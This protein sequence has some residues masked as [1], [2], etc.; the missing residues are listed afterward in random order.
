MPDSNGS[1]IPGSDETDLS[2]AEWLAEVGDRIACGESVDL[3][4]LTADDPGKAERLRRLVPALEMM[5]RL[6]NRPGPPTEPSDGGGRAGGGLLGP[7]G[8]FVTVRELG[9]GGMGVVYEAMQ[10]SLNRPVALKILPAVSADDPSRLRRFRVE[11][12]AAACLSHPHIVPVYLVGS[13]GGT[14]FYAMKLVEGKTLARVIAEARRAT[15]RTGRRAGPTPREAAALAKQAAEALQY[16]HEQGIVHRDVKPSNLLVEAP[17]WL[18]VTDF[19]LARVP[20]AADLSSP[21]ALLCTLRYASP[22]QVVGDRAGVNHRTDV[23][24]LGAT[25]YELVSLRPAFPIDDRIA[26]LKAIAGR[27]PVPLR[28]LDPSV[29][30][31][32]ETVVAKAMAKD[33]ARRYATA[34]ELAD[35]LGRFLDD[36]PIKARPAGRSDRLGKFARRHRGAAAAAVA[37]VAVGAAAAVGASLWRQGILAG[38]NRELAVALRRAERNEW[39]NRKLWYGSQIRLARQ[40]F[41]AGQVEFAQEV[42]DGLR[43]GPRDRDPRGF[44]WFHLRRL[45]GRDLSL[46]FGHEEGVT[47]LAVSA[48]GKTLATGDRGGTVVFWDLDRWRE[49][50]RRKLARGPVRG[51]VF[52]PDGKV[53]ACWTDAPVDLTLL[54]ASAARVLGVL[55]GLRGEVRGAR[56]TPDGATLAALDVGPGPDGAPARAAFFPLQ[57]GPS[58]STAGPKPVPCDRLA[59]S[60]DGRFLATSAGRGA[61]TL[62]EA[63]DG[64]EVTVFPGY[65]EAISSIAFTPDGA[66][67]AARHEGGMTFWDV[68]TGDQSVLTEVPGDGRARF[69]E[70]GARGPAFPLEFDDRA[71]WMVDP[72]AKP[73]VIE[74]AGDVT[75]PGAFA[76]APAGAPWLVA[77]ARFRGTGVWD[78]GGRSVAWF[79]HP[80]SY[81]NALAAAPDGASLFVAAGDDVRVRRWR[82]GA[83]KP[84]PSVRIQAHRSEAWSLAFTPD[85]SAVISS[86]DDH[87]VRLWDPRDG[88]PRGVFRGHTALVSSV[89]ASPEGARFASASFDGTVRVW[90]LSSGRTYRTLRGH[91]GRV[92]TVAYAPGGVCVASGGNDRTVRVWDVESGTAVRTFAGLPSIVRAVAF[93]PGGGRLAAA[94]DDG[95]VLVWDLRSAAGPRSLARGK[96]AASVAFSPDGRTLA[97]GDDGGRVTCWDAAT[98][99]RGPSF[100]GSD[101]PVWGLAFNDDGRTLAAACGDAKVRLW[102]PATGEVLL[103]LEGHERRVNAVAFSPDGRTLASASHEGVVRLWLSDRP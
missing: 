52:S 74:L 50:A 76:F 13:D 49:R 86:A 68:A 43:P 35:D 10:V 72:R 59:F 73:E 83:D 61:V 55:G 28:R 99:A 4:G 88:A 41:A 56:F 100:K 97:V 71:A 103:L 5:A 69:A 6:W 12:Q 9:R 31:D 3:G 66:L 84:E 29:P 93:D 45:F 94:L 82:V 42:L 87:T 36:R 20:G 11:A 78:A 91:E 54:D 53:A 18:W 79:P 39:V 95:A 14:H 40:E 21:G 77:G 98:W 85:G 1:N 7:L 65:F 96:P 34:G 60:R 30:R 81:E 58:G 23:Y 16:A 26:L 25:L 62:R 70:N 8:D 75:G 44:E 27:E 89:A 57:G 47:A 80:R 101:A 17:G 22:E 37:F 19:G 33:A 48:D 32:L 90:D 92:R 63:A 64:R 102:D 51:L 67:L 24:S 2:L 38:H 15:A 46:L